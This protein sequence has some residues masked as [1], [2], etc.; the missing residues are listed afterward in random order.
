MLYFMA[1][2]TLYSAYIDDFIVYNEHTGSHLSHISKV[3]DC[4][5][6]AGITSKVYKV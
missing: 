4:L 3:L 2:M 5:R 1:W 6:K